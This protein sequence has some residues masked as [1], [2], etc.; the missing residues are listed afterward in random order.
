MAAAA[1]A[2]GEGGGWRVEGGA[3]ARGAPA[4]RAGRHTPSTDTWSKRTTARGG[5]RA[6]PTGR[7][8]ASR[9]PGGGRG[10]TTPATPA[11]AR[12]RRAAGA[13]GRRCVGAADTGGDA[14]TGVGGAPPA[15]AAGGSSFERD[16]RQSSRRALLRQSDANFTQVSACSDGASAIARTS[17]ISIHSRSSRLHVRSRWRHRVRMASQRA[18]AAAPSPATAPQARAATPP[19]PRAADADAAGDPPQAEMVLDDFL[20]FGELLRA[21]E[22]RVRARVCVV[23]GGGE[24]RRERGARGGVGRRVHVAPV[25]DSED[26]A[27]EAA[28]VRRGA[29]E[30]D[31]RASPPTRGSTTAPPR[32][33]ARPRAAARR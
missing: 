14:D 23:G 24:L 31:G 30:H 17:T 8:R 6:A 7:P 32:A 12:R 25:V 21:D 4:R 1:A 18:R 26:R 33:T 20:Q 2:G 3:N 29:D 19:P 15:A 27:V 10:A 5:C 16:A 11:R 28:L 13:G 9:P 22:R